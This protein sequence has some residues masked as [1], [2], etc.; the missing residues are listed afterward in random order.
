[1][2]CETKDFETTKIVVRYPDNFD[3]AKKYP[4]IIALHGAGYRGE[5]TEYLK[6]NP[7]FTLTE[8]HKDFPFILVAP[9]CN[10]N[11]WFDLFPTLKNLAK[12]LYNHKNTDPE[13]LYLMGASMGG[14]GT[15]QLAMSVP[16][17]FAAI[18]PICGGGMYWS[19]SRLVNVPT[20]AFH[21]AKDDCVL[22]RESEKMVEVLKKCGGD[23]RLTVYPNEYHHSWVPTYSNPEVFE[24][25]L[26]HKNK[27]SKEII[28]NCI[29]NF[30]G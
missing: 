28:D 3:K 21:G 20:W 16:E 18:V 14:Y 15:W 29:G 17:L 2:F 4:T 8:K 9:I 23:V 7:I 25:L 27:N 30:Y 6:Q 26:S 1:M 13:R 24:W 19:A 10:Q 12:M 11:S 22:L 5:D